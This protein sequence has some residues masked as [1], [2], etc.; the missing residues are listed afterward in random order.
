MTNGS[1]S[2][3]PANP[4]DDDLRTNYEAMRSALNS[5]NISRGV[6]RS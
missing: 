3:F 1:A 6:F 4:P 2:R 5:A